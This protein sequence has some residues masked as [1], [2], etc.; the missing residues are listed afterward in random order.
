[1]WALGV[2]PTQTDFD[3]ISVQSQQM[4]GAYGLASDVK[5]FLAGGPSAGNQNFGLRGLVSSGLNPTAQFVGSYSW[6]MSRSGGNLNI[7]LKNS[8]TAWSAPYHAPLLNPNPP[9]RS[10][11]RPMGRVNQTFHLSV[12][13]P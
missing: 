6:S 9:T 2:G 4:M 5:A 11:W 8:T 12:P 3:P 1:M 13:R 10:G 7:T